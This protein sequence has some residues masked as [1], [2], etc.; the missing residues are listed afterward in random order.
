MRGNS[1]LRR[2]SGGDFSR[3]QNP[4]IPKVPTDSSEHRDLHCS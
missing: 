3:I 1:V 4:Q 2:A